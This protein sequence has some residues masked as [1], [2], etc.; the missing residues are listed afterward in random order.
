[1]VVQG[2]AP[3]NG[4][5]LRRALHLK[6]EEGVRRERDHLKVEGLGGGSHRWRRSAA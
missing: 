3:R 6:E 2:G 5:R 1:M 4:V